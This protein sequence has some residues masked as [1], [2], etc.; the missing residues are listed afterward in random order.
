[1]ALEQKTK[2]EIRLAPE[3]LRQ[4]F[5]TDCPIFINGDYEL[6]RKMASVT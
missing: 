3:L 2:G 5:I 4:E 6:G 1:M